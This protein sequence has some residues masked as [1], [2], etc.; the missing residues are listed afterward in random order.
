MTY[1]RPR[2]LPAIAYP[3]VAFLPVIGAAFALASGAAPMVTALGAYVIAAAAVLVLERRWPYSRAW[4]IPHGD[5][6]VDVTHLFVDTLL[7]E[8]C[9][10]VLTLYVVVMTPSLARWWPRSW[11]LGVQLL[12]ALIFFELVQYVA[13]LAMHRIPWLWP[14]HAVHHSPERL[15]L[16]STFRNHPIDSLLTVAIPLAPLALAGAGHDLL[17][18]TGIAV[19]TH[20]MVQHSNIDFARG[21]V[22][23]F[24]STATLH[25][26]HHS[27]VG[28]EGEGNYG[29]TL[30]LWDL[31]FRTRRIPRTGA[32]SNVGLRS[33]DFPRTYVGQLLF[34][35]RSRDLE[36]AR[37]RYE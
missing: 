3:V 21:R 4:L 10:R 12:V 6:R 17:V 13:H 28:N 14:F 33:V 34:P 32:F 25:R 9:L 5:L 27:R 2:P 31:L 29:G 22:D 20:S 37:H 16:A 35:L 11:P 18:L 30:I 8:A 15:H 24:L 7:G 1:A 36:A 26:W 23:D 19:G